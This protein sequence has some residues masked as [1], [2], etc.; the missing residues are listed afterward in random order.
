MRPIVLPNIP[1]MSLEKLN[2]DDPAVKELRE[3]LIGKLMIQQEQMKQEY[4]TQVKDLSEL[5]AKEKELHLWKRVS[6]LA[7]AIHG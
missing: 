1:R 3:Q 5:E 6:W 4:E 2:L 7:I